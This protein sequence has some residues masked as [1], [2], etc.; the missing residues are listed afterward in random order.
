M[1][2]VNEAWAIWLEGSS[3]DI[4]LLR[5]DALSDRLLSFGSLQIL[6]IWIV[7]TGYMHRY[8]ETRRMRPLDP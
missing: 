6:E 4:E 7:L 8:L 3:D 5:S 1:G 2:S